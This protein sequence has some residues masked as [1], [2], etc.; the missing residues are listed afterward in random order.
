MKGLW[1]TLLCALSVAIAADVRVNQLGFYP[2]TT[3]QFVVTNASTDSFF[4]RNVSDDAIVAKGKLPAP[5]T[6]SGSGES[7]QLGDF[8]SLTTEGYYYI[9]VK[10]VGRSSPFRI[11]KDLYAQAYRDAM[12][13]FYFWRCSD[14]ISL[15]NG[16]LF[17]RPFAHADNAVR[18]H[19]SLNKGTTATRDVSRGWYDAG[20][21][22]KYV[23]NAGVTMGELQ[24]FQTM[25]PNWTADGTLNIPE[26]K[27]GKADIEDELRWEL[28][29]LL[30]MQDETSGGV[31]FKVSSLSFGA[32][33][34][35]HLDTKLERFVIGM[36]TGSTLTFAAV[37]AQ[38][39]RRY[40]VSD[41]TYSTKLLNAAKKAYTWA[42]TYPDSQYSQ[43]AG[44]AY[45][46]VSTGAYTS[47][48]DDFSDELLWAKA[49]LWLATGTATY[50][51]VAASLPSASNADWGKVG[52]LALYSLALEGSADPT[53]QNAAKAKI[54]EAADNLVIA[55]AASSYGVPDIGFGWGSNGSMASMALNLVL[56][57][58]T[59]T[60]DTSY[61]RVATKIADYFMGKNPL[62]IS[63]LTGI[64]YFNVTSPHSRVMMGDG[65]VPPIPG[66]IAGG[67]NTSLNDSY[68]KN[69][70]NGCIGAQCFVD[71][72]S[73]YS[74]NEIAN[75]W[76]S[77][78]VA[79]LGSIEAIM[80]G[81]AKV[82]DAPIS[83]GLSVAS[84]GN[85][86]SVAATPVKTSYSKG[87]LVR[88]VVTTK[89]GYKF[90]GWRGS[91]GGI[92]ADTSFSIQGDCYVIPVFA[93]LNTE[94]ILNGGF[95]KDVSN[96]TAS[97]VVTDANDVVGYADL[98]YQK[99]STMKIVV[100]GTGSKLASASVFQ[101][102]LLLG[103]NQNYTLEFDA[104]SDAARIIGVSFVNS[105]GTVVQ[106]YNNLQV[107]PDE[108]HIR[109]SFT[110]SR[111]L[112]EN[113]KIRF[114]VGLNSSNV[115]V[116]NVSM[117]M[118]DGAL[119]PD[120]VSVRPKLERAHN[121]PVIQNGVLSVSAE[122]GAPIS[123]QIFDLGGRTTAEWKGYA[124][125]TIQMDL[126]KLDS[127]AN[128]MRI[129]SVQ[130]SKSVYSIR[131][132]ANQ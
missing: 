5:I 17:Q 14:S 8:S 34:L 126:Q 87:D 80:G 31:Y 10:N 26:S 121:A 115:Y 43:G 58:Q 103:Q 84:G 11:R 33:V 4:V 98:Q 61:I 2:N 40:S 128:G 59:G 71:N 13:A 47:G 30:R 111:A 95:T 99:D 45:A 41:P 110:Y 76:Q 108:H 72:S 124:N 79:L 83:F 127:Q 130:I 77:A 20:D 67:P 52:T 123:V 125:G 18:Y 62:G 32:M 57:F 39:S 118:I 19:P 88:L 23:V 129:V 7:A 15:E 27:N 116:D 49:E 91:L 60:K 37:A 68:S 9:Q 36:S 48:N 3:K 90:L 85:G 132:Q 107:L 46:N 117:K 119:P 78:I 89:T 105:A 21:Y 70:L 102:G 29:W 94:M 63:Y 35:P 120:L 82:A 44:T 6:W 74:T 114:E 113:V 112:A 25:F 24:V 53:L 65:V 51:P 38:A 16:G 101:S 86:G 69:A 96:W 54:K 66:Y 42:S 1:I 92:N 75:N 81:K 131:W 100:Y 64:G 104:R 12:R 22:G 122:N 50:K 73:S 56:A 109:L 28:D 106:T 97:S 93:K 55:V